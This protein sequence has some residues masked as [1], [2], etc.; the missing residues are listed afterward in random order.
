MPETKA[1]RQPM[2]VMRQPM[3][4]QEYISRV[5]S[6]QLVRVRVR[7]KVR[8]RVYGCMGAWV[9]G[10]GCMGWGVWVGVGVRVTRRRL[11]WH[12]RAY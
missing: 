11:E 2:H 4:D 12:G 6:M 8:V 5:S 9:R 1:P 10:L 3:P 7:V